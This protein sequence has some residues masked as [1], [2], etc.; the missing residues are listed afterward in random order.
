MAKIRTTPLIKLILEKYHQ[1]RIQNSSQ[2]IDP[3]QS[4]VLEPVKDSWFQYLGITEKNAIISN[5]DFP[6]AGGLS[7]DYEVALRSNPEQKGNFDY[8]HYVY[9]T[10]YFYIEDNQKRFLGKAKMDDLA[11]GKVFAIALL[12]HL[13]KKGMACRSDEEQ[14][15]VRRN[16]MQFATF[17][18]NLSAISDS[19]SHDD[20]LISCG[21]TLEKICAANK[22]EKEGQNEITKLFGSVEEAIVAAQT[23]IQDVNNY[24]I[25]TLT[26]KDDINS[27]FLN[28]LFSPTHGM[29]HSSTENEFLSNSVALEIFKKPWLL[30]QEEEEYKTLYQGIEYTFTQEPQPSFIL[31]QFTSVQKENLIKLLQL[32]DRLQVLHQEFNRLLGFARENIIGNLNEFLHLID[33]YLKEIHRV[34]RELNYRVEKFD[35]DCFNLYF[36]RSEAPELFRSKRE[37]W[38]H[39]HKIRHPL[40]IK[41][42]DNLSILAQKVASTFS[43]IPFDFFASLEKFSHE[44]TEV[45]ARGKALFGDEFN[46]SSSTFQT[47]INE[48]Q[49]KELLRQADLILDKQKSIAKQYEELI[50]KANESFDSNKEELIKL[51]TTRL[52][53]V[54][55][56]IASFDKPKEVVDLGE[57]EDAFDA[58][59]EGFVLLSPSLSH[60]EAEHQTGGFFQLVHNYL[61][62]PSAV[63]FEQLKEQVAR[64][65]IELEEKDSLIASK[66]EIIQKQKT[67][68]SEKDRTIAEKD[69]IN[70]Y[71]SVQLFVSKGARLE[72]QK[73]WLASLAN[74]WVLNSDSKTSLYYYLLN[75]EDTNKANKVVTF[76]SNIQVLLNQATECAEAYRLKAGE[77]DKSFFFSHNANGREHAWKIINQWKCVVERL[78]ATEI[79]S[80]GIESLSSPGGLLDSINQSII[81]LVTDDKYSSYK[82]HSFRNYT[83]VLYEQS[84]KILDP[85]TICSEK[86]SGLKAQEV[87]EQIQ[88]TEFNPDNL[89]AFCKN[90]LDSIRGKTKKEAEENADLE[91]LDNSKCFI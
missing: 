11:H 49:G 15:D 44:A 19:S 70:D 28:D 42:R 55:N 57:S 4:I 9:N 38:E 64:L 67:V 26:E 16:I 35:L 30:N 82:Q 23:A 58:E 52:E 60:L 75:T 66:D 40:L 37:K 18:Q 31:S 56:F 25:L 62:A 74:S 43:N 1:Y 63:A 65:N 87:Y 48:A 13:C 90:P 27:S 17:L 24:L 80:N 68:I 2:F 54:N 78:I 84:A 10:C 83:R 5:L 88:G 59:K 21:S 7:N 85:E 91:G 45:L 69:A 50:A 8:F 71:L 61:T 36:T 81:S 29:V 46:E 14:E 32:R 22:K 33:P 39:Y 20:K 47:A 73:K 89:K 34:N 72:E 12:S 86:K 41:I 53:L 51:L 77:Y 79:N 3:T 6:I 76:L